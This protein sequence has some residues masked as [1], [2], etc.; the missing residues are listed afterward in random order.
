MNKIIEALDID[1]L[2]ASYDYVISIVNVSFNGIR[3]IWQHSEDQSAKNAC[4][5]FLS[6]STGSII[7][8]IPC[9]SGHSFQFKLQTLPTQ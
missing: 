6:S 3:N 5:N 2:K 4:G 1:L 8:S 9:L 7:M